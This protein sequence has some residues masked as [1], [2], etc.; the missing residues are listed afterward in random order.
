[1]L[2]SYI[3]LPLKKL[4]KHTHICIV[5]EAAATCPDCRRGSCGAPQRQRLPRGTAR[6]SHSS[7]AGKVGCAPHPGGV[8]PIPSHPVPSQGRA[9]HPIPGV[10]STF[11]ECAPLS[12]E[13]APHPGSVPPIPGVCSPSHLGGVPPSRGCVPH[14][15]PRKGQD[16]RTQPRAGGSGTAPGGARVVPGISAVVRTE[17]PH[18]IPLPLSSPSPNPARGRHRAAALPARSWLQDGSQR[19]RHSWHI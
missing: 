2:I 4:F 6:S 15:V 5:N 17:H 16:P 9:P 14:P 3:L 19:P 8:P 7:A 11:W 13:C 1:M 10:C 12:Q 18:R